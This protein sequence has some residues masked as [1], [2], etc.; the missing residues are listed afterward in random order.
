MIKLIAAF[1]KMLKLFLI[2][3]LVLFANNAAAGG[4]STTIQT[5]QSPSVDST[6]QTYSS[7]PVTQTVRSGNNTEV[8]VPKDPTGISQAKSEAYLSKSL[9][10][11]LRNPSYLNN[12]YSKPLTTDTLMKPTGASYHCT[13]HIGNIYTSLSDCNSD[14]ANGTCSPIEANTKLICPSSKQFLNIFAEPSATGDVTAYIRADTG[15]TGSFTDSIT[16]PPISG[17]CTNGFVSCDSGTWHNCKYYTWGIRHKNTGNGITYNSLRECKTH[18]MQKCSTLNKCSTNG[19]TYSSLKQCE[20]SCPIPTCELT[21]DKMIHYVQQTGISSL[22]NCFAINKSVGNIFWNDF[23]NIMTTLGGGLIDHLSGEENIAVTRSKLDQ[24]SMSLGYYGADTAN[25]S[26]A[27]N[28]NNS[29]N[30]KSPNQLKQ[31]YQSGQISGADAE[32]FNQSQDP[33]SYYSQLA[34]SNYMKQNPVNTYTCS[35]KR[36]LIFNHGRINT[37]TSKPCTVAPQCNALPIVG[38]ILKCTYFNQN[39]YS[40][41][42]GG[43]YRSRY[44]CNSYCASGNC[45]M[46][47]SP[48]QV[49]TQPACSVYKGF[50]RIYT[51]SC[52]KKHGKDEANYRDKRIYINNGNYVIYA[53]AHITTVNSCDPQ[54][55]CRLE[56]EEVCDYNGTNCLTTVSNYSPAGVPVFPSC[57]TQSDSFTGGS[58]NFCSNGSTINY[59]GTSSGVLTAG[60]DVYWTVKKTYTCSSKKAAA[61]DVTRARTVNTGT[62]YRGSQLHYAD[63]LQGHSS[64]NI[65][66]DLSGFK[67]NDCIPACIVIDNN[68]KDTVVPNRGNPV[69]GTQTTKTKYLTCERTDPQSAYT[70][71]VPSG[72]TLKQDCGCI[73]GSARAISALTTADEAAHDL[74]CSQ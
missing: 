18:I 40:Y 5:Y 49:T 29:Y 35:I 74:I 41:T 31:D 54:P 9:A 26:A 45:S 59:T 34:G 7:P 21:T 27:S 46:T 14:C 71:P 57:I 1:S 13:V 60:T 62:S 67:K 4:L 51:G 72:Y 24:T 17:V 73:D 48:A 32:V 3:T 19:K 36:R 61:P 56:K 64:N 53:V 37:L 15:L 66:I 68:K 58:W 39:Q 44:D 50:E 10:N 8:N 52:H 2:V 70:C 47:G 63:T 43:Q 33:N 42:I 25:C 22:G 30:G 23:D 6:M 20:S 11:S 69:N 65:N 55:D 38:N 12:N 28:S 16:T